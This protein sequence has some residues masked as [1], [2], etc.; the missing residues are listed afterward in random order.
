[1][2]TLSRRGWTALA[3]AASLVVAG[4]VIAAVWIRKA[5][6]QYRAGHPQVRVSIAGGCPS[7]LGAAQDVH[8]SGGGLADRFAPPGPSAG[9]VCRYGPDSRSPGYPPRS[10]L[11]RSVA[12]SRAQA[13]SLTG[14]LNRLRLGTDVGPHSCPPPELSISILVFSYP[15]HSDVD[16]WY[17]GTGCATVD[18]GQRDAAEIGNPPF[19]NGFAPAVDR[20]APPLD[21]QPG[22]ASGG[23]AKSKTIQ[24]VNNRCRQ[25]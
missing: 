12:I 10:A 17:A 11:Y 19:Y 25:R 3:V 23:P 1:M 15:Q 7:T 9:L 18:N 5:S 21:E 2:T 16:I 14:L 24:T 4:G 8:N 13:S 20:L 6:P 22:F